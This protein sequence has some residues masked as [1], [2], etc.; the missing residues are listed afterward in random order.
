MGGADW[1]NTRIRNC[2]RP[3]SSTS[4]TNWPP[5]MSD[6]RAFVRRSSLSVGQLFSMVSVVS[7]LLA[8]DPTHL[9]VQG[10]RR[11]PAR[12]RLA[13]AKIQPPAVLPATGR[14]LLLT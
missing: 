12:L 6:A 2:F 9:F 1:N 7:R 14:A 13:L 4:S 5:C 3:H 8:D 11:L 10:A